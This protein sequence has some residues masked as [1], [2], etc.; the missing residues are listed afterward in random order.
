[1][2]ERGLENEAWDLDDWRTPMQWMAFGLPGQPTFPFLRMSTILHTGV[3]LAAVF[4]LCD[5][6][7]LQK[8]IGH[9]A[10]VALMSAQFSQISSPKNL[11]LNT[12]YISLR[13]Q[14]TINCMA[15]NS[16]N[17]FFHSSGGQT[18]ETE[19]QAGLCGEM[20]PFF[21]QFWMALSGPWL[22]ITPTSTSVVTLPATP[23]LCVCVFSHSV[24][25]KVSGFRVHLGNSELS[26]LK[27]FN[28]ITSVKIFFPTKVTLIRVW[29]LGRRHIFFRATF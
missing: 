4:I 10:Y 23:F 12:Y 3:A 9:G 14:I 11:E 28:L 27:I 26:H 13:A 15:S 1:M 5:S 18:P 20:L 29:I 25:Y 21:F 19:A 7:R 16:R 2:E 22:Y 24:S 6:S 17:L 8:V